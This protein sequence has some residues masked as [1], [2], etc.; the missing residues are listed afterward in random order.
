M[1]VTSR[2]MPGPKGSAIVSRARLQKQRGAI[3]RW[4]AWV[5]LLVSFLGS[6]AALHGGWPPLIGS[7][8][9]LQPRWAAL[10]GGFAIQAVL[11]YLEWH[12][13]DVPLIAWSARLGDAVTT[14]LGY[15][16]LVI[17]VLIA[18]LT[19]E[20]LPDPFFVAWGIIGLVSLLA[21]WY[22]ESRLVE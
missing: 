12:Y 5:V 2:P 3:E 21:A 1:A 10:L 17:G 11:T 15:G 18:R 16:P 19:S 7:L 8:L 14:A 9:A 20:T 6:I 13:F 4:S 22:P